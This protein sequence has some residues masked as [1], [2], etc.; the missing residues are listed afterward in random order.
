MHLLY[1]ECT[2]IYLKGENLLNALITRNDGLLFVIL[3][4]VSLSLWVQKYKVFKSLGPVLTVV[5]LGIILSNTHI[6]P[7]SHDLYGEIS[8]Y[9]VPVAISVCMLSMNFKELKKPVSYTH[10]DVYKRQL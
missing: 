9:L 7:I 4:M 2:T 1:N 6:V 8:T 3:L 10:L 5:V